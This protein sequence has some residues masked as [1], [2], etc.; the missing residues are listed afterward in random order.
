M[1]NTR[2]VCD[3]LCIKK[4][5]FSLSVTVC[6]VVVRG[7]CCSVEFRASPAWGGVLEL[8]DKY[9]VAD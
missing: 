4:C 5:I 6:A 3:V 9:I 2:R 1:I 8:D 7:Q